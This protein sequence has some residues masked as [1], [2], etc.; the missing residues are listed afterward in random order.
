MKILRCAGGPLP[1]VSAADVPPCPEDRSGVHYC[2]HKVKVNPEQLEF[3]SPVPP[4]LHYCEY[5][6]TPFQGA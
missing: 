1:A 6:N 4:N 5:C 2:G 3:G